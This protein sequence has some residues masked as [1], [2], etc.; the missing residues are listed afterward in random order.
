MTIPGV[1]ALQHDRR[2]FGDKATWLQ[3]LT[4]TAMPHAASFC[5]EHNLVADDSFTW[6]NLF[7]EGGELLDALLQLRDYE[8]VSFMALQMVLADV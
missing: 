7:N 5:F 6:K 8:E 1:G 2:D 4:T 3:T